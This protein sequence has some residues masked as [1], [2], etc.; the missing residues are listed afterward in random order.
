MKQIFPYL[1]MAGTT[2]VVREWMEKTC[3]DH[4]MY[5]TLNKRGP[6][7]KNP[8]RPDEQSI[9]VKRAHLLKTWSISEAGCHEDNI[10]A[11]T[12]SGSRQS[13]EKKN[14]QA[15]YNRARG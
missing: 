6:T 3:A 2:A 10:P 7:D 11:T 14:R 9:N 1:S 4:M 12:G 5:A 15:Q 8:K 13:A